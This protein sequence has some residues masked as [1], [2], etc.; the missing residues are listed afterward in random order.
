MASRCISKALTIN[1]IQGQASPDI[2]SMQYA[3]CTELSQWSEKGYG[4]I[5]ILPRI[6]ETKGI[7][8]YSLSNQHFDKKFVF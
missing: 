7:V 2:F 8:D 6:P 4:H 5:V 3:G 1:I